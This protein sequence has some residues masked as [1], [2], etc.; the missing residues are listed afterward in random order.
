MQEGFECSSVIVAHPTILRKI[1]YFSTLPSSGIKANTKAAA[2][3]G[4]FAHHTSFSSSLL[5]FR[6]ASSRTIRIA[7]LVYLPVRSR[8]MKTVSLSFVTSVAILTLS[9]WPFDLCKVVLVD[10]RH[11]PDPSAFVCP[12]HLCL[13]LMS[14]PCV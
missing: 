10:R 14:D 13:L 3:L 6:D 11:Q 5:Y 1:N 9:L 2:L 4:S 12:P 7:R 8:P